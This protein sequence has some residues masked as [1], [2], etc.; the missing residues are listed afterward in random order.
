MRAP[1][2][3]AHDGPQC[4]LTAALHPAVG[5]FEQDAEVGLQDLGSLAGE[6]AQAVTRRLD[7]LAVVADPGDVDGWPQRTRCDQ[8]C[9][10]QG[11]R[12]P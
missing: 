3:R 6:P 11:D 7:L 5:R 9:Y 10:P 12:Y 4:A 2:G 1:S 8:V